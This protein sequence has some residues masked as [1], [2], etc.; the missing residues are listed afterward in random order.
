M[1]AIRAEGVSKNFLPPQVPALPTF[2]VQKFISQVLVE[3]GYDYRTGTIHSTDFRFWEFDQRF[4]DNLIEERVLAVEMETHI[5]YALAQTAQQLE[6]YKTAR[7][8]Y[9]RLG[10]YA[11]P[12]S[13]RDSIDLAIV[14]IQ[15]KPFKFS[16]LVPT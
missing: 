1:A 8:A 12:S 11:V 15:A 16:C 5:L 13:W 2:K 10:T 9:D 14:S 4:K 7:W 3:N 6:A